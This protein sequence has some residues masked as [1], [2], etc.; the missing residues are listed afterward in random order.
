M[1]ALAA[2]LTCAVVW[3]WTGVILNSKM[4]NGLRV[5]SVITNPFGWAIVAAFVFTGLSTYLYRGLT[6]IWRSRLDQCFGND[7]AQATKGFGYCDD[8][9]IVGIVDRKL[10]EL[11]ATVPGGDAINRRRFWRA[12]NA[13]WAF[14]F[15]VHDLGYHMGM[16]KGGKK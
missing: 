5:F 7:V 16:G 3:Q 4:D 14:G 12:N 9:E 2:G 6:V 1:L 8:R 15:T 10:A 11:A 13:A